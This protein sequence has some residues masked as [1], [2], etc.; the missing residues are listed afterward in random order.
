MTALAAA[1]QRRCRLLGGCLHIAF[2]PNQSV[3]GFTGSPLRQH[4]SRS[5]P[6]KKQC[7]ASAA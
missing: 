3:D 7:E 5:Q 2:Q 6:V 4:S 1:V